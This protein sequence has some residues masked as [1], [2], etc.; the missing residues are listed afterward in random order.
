MDPVGEIIIQF[1][2]VGGIILHNP[3]KAGGIP[4]GETQRPDECDIIL[5]L[6]EFQQVAPADNNCL[7]ICLFR[8]V[9]CL[10]VACI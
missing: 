7:Y 3:A 9:F 2:D 4:P 5:I 6:R 10:H 1:F 8:V